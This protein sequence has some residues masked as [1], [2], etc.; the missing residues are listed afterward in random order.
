MNY[1]HLCLSHVHK[2][3]FGTDTLKIYLTLFY[4]I[5]LYTE[6]QKKLITTSERHSLNSTTVKLIIFGHRY[7]IVLLIK[8]IWKSKGCFC[9]KGEKC[10]EISKGRVFFFKNHSTKGRL[11]R[12]F[13]SYSF[14]FKGGLC[15]RRNGYCPCRAPCPGGEH[16]LW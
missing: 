10:G 3:F 8:H 16:F 6:R 7:V 9:Q 5:V 14:I 12:T 1:V 4:C 15:N 2:Y 11:F 13:N